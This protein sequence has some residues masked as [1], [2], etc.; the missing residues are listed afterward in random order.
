MP[1]IDLNIKA[2]VQSLGKN[3]PGF[4]RGEASGGLVV[5]DAHAR[6]QELA[7]QGNAYSAANQAAQAVSVALATTY[8]GLLVYN[9]IG[10][11]IILV[12][13]KVKF[14]LS[15]A[16]AGIASIGLISGFQTA[17]P[18]GLTALSVRSNQIGNSK[19]GVGLA[20][21]AAT[22]ATPVWFQ[23]LVDGFTAAALPAPSPVVD[24]EGLYVILPGG[25][26][27]FGAL[28]AVTGLGSMSW[29]EIPL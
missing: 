28:T 23:Q 4:L 20:Y 9:P 5:Q 13:N 15:V 18:T 14:A 19:T 2:G 17:A 6:Y 7:Y 24:L 26:I 1:G 27:A 22:I 12:P 16:P 29:E 10:S 11:G 25:F 21:S 8:T 3:G